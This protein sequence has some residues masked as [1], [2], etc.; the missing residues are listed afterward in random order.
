MSKKRLKSAVDNMEVFDAEN[1][2]I[3]SVNPR[4]YSLDVVYYAAYVLLDRAYVILGG[5]PKKKILVELRPKDNTDLK[6]L[7]REFNNEL[8]NYAVYLKQSA[9]NQK[10]KEAI[11]QRV[12]MTNL[13]P[14]E[15]CEPNELLGD[16]GGITK[17][18]GREHGR[19][20]KKG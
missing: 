16:P 6:S 20:K 12:L 8:L 4:I 19:K 7:G 5:D 3:L 10:L 18:W 2:L 9:K 11:L 14:V 1:Y 15:G 13:A 17:P